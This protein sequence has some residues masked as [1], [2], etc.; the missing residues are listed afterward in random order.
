VLPLRLDAD[1]QV[2]AGVEVGH[3][4]PPRCLLLLQVLVLDQPPLGETLVLLHL[5][6]LLQ[7]LRLLRELLVVEPI[8]VLLFQFSVGAVGQLVVQVAPMWGVNYLKLSFFWRSSMRSLAFMRSNYM[9]LYLFMMAHSSRCGEAS[10]VSS[11]AESLR[12]YSV[13]FLIIKIIM[14][15]SETIQE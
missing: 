12:D 15:E 7:G 11:R 10:M 9:A 5:L 1:L 4:R 14:Q 2:V 6:P 8:L 3:P 13:L